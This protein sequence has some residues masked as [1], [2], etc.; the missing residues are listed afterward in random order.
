L[1]ERANPKIELTQCRLQKLSK[2]F[3][4][5]ERR[6]ASLRQLSFL[7]LGHVPTCSVVFTWRH[8]HV[9]CGWRVL[10]A[11]CMTRGHLPGRWQKFF[12]WTSVSGNGK[13]VRRCGNYLWC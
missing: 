9:R 13:A 3:N 6:A 1:S 10:W 7:Y 5:M 8:V 11:P 12:F 2:I 4:D